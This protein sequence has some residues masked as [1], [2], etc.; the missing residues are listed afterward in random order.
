[1]KAEATKKSGQIIVHNIM[2]TQNNNR[3][4]PDGSERYR[5]VDEQ[6]E[7]NDK[8]NLINKKDLEWLAWN[9]RAWNNMTK[10]KDRKAMVFGHF[11]KDQQLLPSP[12]Q[13]LHGII[14]A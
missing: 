9:W 13:I 1:M 3:L 4:R 7:S 14:L 11:I 10:Y 2:R 5:Y 8:L 6:S 12:E